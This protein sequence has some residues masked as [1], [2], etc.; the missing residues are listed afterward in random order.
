MDT[1][2]EQLCHDI[3]YNCHISDARFAGNYTLCIYLLKMREYYRWEMACD[4]GQ[5]LAQDAVGDW[6][7]QR[8]AHWDEIEQSDYRKLHINKLEFDPFH[9]DAINRQL[10]PYGLVYSGGYGIKSKPHF[11]IAELE[12]QQNHLDYTIYISNKEFARDLTSPPAMSHG[13]NIYIRREAFKRLLW[14]R[15]EEWRWNKPDNAMA[16]AIACYDFDHNLNDAL[17]AMTDN[18]LNMA[19]FHEIGEIQA[20]KQLTGWQAMMGEISFTQAE[21]MAR[22]VRDHYADTLYTLPEL[23]QAGYS[24]K[25]QQASL[26]FYFANLTSMRKHLFPSLVTAYQQW[27]ENGDMDSLRER[28]TSG[29]K[30]WQYISQE[31]LSRYTRMQAH[32]GRESAVK[33]I[34]ML[35]NENK[36]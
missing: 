29:K 10:L 30:H 35:V 3:Q 25:H 21:I 13:K 20:G 12:Q 33:A 34:E 14:E 17:D 2:L 9:S 19:V 8:E 6:L 31:I 22:A 28:I 27:L 18:E 7:S 4:F 24:E 36:L 16:R 5:P 23:L 15:T 11:F 26:H 32:S 1:T